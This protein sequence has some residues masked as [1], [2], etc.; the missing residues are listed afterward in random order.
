MQRRQLAVG[1]AWSPFEMIGGPIWSHSSPTSA[2]SRWPRSDANSSMQ[3]TSCHWSEP[4]RH[5]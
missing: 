3:R 4:D 5:L 2:K 1:N